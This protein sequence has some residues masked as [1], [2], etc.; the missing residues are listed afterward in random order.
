MYEEK[1]ISLKDLILV[2]FKNIKLILIVGIVTGLLGVGYT[3]LTDKEVKLPEDENSQYYVDLKSYQLE[4]DTYNFSINN[5]KRIIE[6]TVNNINYYNNMLEN[7][8]YDKLDEFNIYNSYFNIMASGNDLYEINNLLVEDSFLE[9]ISDKFSI[10]DLR[11]LIT[12]GVVVNE[13]A[14][15]VT[16]RVY[17]GSSEDTKNLIDNITSEVIVRGFDF[18]LGQV[19]SDNGYSEYIYNAKNKLIST[20]ANF[21]S[22][23]ETAKGQLTSLE[24]TQLPEDPSK[25]SNGLVLNTVIATILGIF[26]ALGI[27]FLKFFLNDSLL[28]ASEINFYNQLPIFGVFKRKKSKIKLINYLET[29]LKEY[30]EYEVYDVI[31][32]NLNVL[33]YE[34]IALVSSSITTLELNN[35]KDKLTRVNN[36]L[37]I[38]V[39]DG[40]MTSAVNINALKNA[41]NLL[42]VEKRMLSKNRKIQE[43]TDYIKSINKKIIGYI[44]Y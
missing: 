11:V 17:T 41:D 19:F 24:K 31:S 13:Q 4:L 36:S 43:L 39:L 20:L 16:V 14:S 15:F 40:D 34:N 28:R 9:A 26:I 37:K 29:D 10:D 6:N 8:T 35:L 12:N 7:I 21:Q 3:F 33:N 27:I 2:C 1:E 32:A 18:E 22:D 5:Q 42:L 23:L 38:K 44:V 25:E 30:D